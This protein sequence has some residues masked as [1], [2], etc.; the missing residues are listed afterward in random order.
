MRHEWTEDDEARMQ[1][2]V[3]AGKGPKSVAEALGVSYGTAKRKVQAYH[4]HARY[5]KRARKVIDADSVALTPFAQLSAL[6]QATIRRLWPQINAA[7]ASEAP[8]RR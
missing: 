5:A 1:E 2:L 3:C 7:M 6:N 4:S 8:V